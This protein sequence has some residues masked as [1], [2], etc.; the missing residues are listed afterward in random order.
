MT[1]PTLVVMAAGMGS[2]YGGLKQVAPVGPSGEIIVDYSLYD[3]LQAGFGRVVFVIKREIEDVFRERVGRAAEKVMDTHYVFQELTDLPPGYALP[4]NRV[5][6]WGTGHAVLAA[7]K[8]ISGPFAV[9]N[10]DDFYGRASFQAIA[11]FLRTARDA[12]DGYQYALVGYP[13]E[14]TLTENGHV[15]RGVC[16]VKDGR[17]V[18][19]VERTRIK[20][21]GQDVRYTED[22]EVWQA[23]P[24]GT[25]V[26]MNLWGFTPSLLLE[27]EARFPAFLETAKAN[28]LKAEYF[29]PSVVD[30]LIK[31]GKAT[32]DVLPTNERWFGVTYP[33]DLPL[34]KQ[35]IVS[36][37]EQGNYPDPLW[38]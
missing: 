20:A 37:I 15:S 10:G 5:K 18:D 6:P 13:V 14:N 8:A 17:L 35:A 25:P 16:T 7:R 12:E 30:A 28:P 36:H 26:S 3:A 27:L 29:L 1:K 4:E 21:A 23:I 11:D 38:T 2:R 31:E 33:E 9:I 34:V 32:A 24:R 19:I 22:G